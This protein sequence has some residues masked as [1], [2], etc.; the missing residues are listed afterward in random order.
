MPRRSLRYDPVALDM[1]LARDDRVVTHSELRTLRFPLSTA[2]YHC[3]VGG[4]WQAH[5]PGVIIAHSGT[6]TPHQREIA[7]VKYA[8][9]GAVLT[10]AAA[11][12]RSGVHRVPH[13][14]ALRVIVAAS[15]RRQ[16]R[17]EVLV[18]RSYRVPE[19]RLLGGIPCA[20]VA[21]ALID[22]CRQGRPLDDT[23][24]LVAAV[25][26]AGHCTVTDLKS[27]LVECQ[28]RGSGIPRAVV[29]EVAAGVRSVSEARA[30][31]VL[32]R[33]GLGRCEWNVS[34]WDEKG[35]FIA[36]PDGWFDAEAVAFES[37]SM[38]WHLSPEDYKRTQRRQKLMAAAG[39]LVVPVAPSDL[40]RDPDAFVATMRATL[41]RGAARPR[42]PIVVTRSP[43]AA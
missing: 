27:E 25:V 12:R 16:S 35:N 24:S 33:A 19:P 31:K 29:R 23:R 28:R 41:L 3:R 7:A 4:P 43:A 34:L 20:P 5:L 26:Q 36:R 8:G 22:E 38:E 32:L 6:P 40:D 1:L 39:V 17:P 18:E 37:D 21:R 9:E 13:P 11:L 2:T 14:A 30:R 15:V 42:P 10:G